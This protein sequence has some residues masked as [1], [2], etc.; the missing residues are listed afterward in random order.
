[1]GGTSQTLHL[2][3][4]KMNKRYNQWHKETTAQWLNEE[5]K[6]VFKWEPIKVA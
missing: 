5:L 3:S 6:K 2:K 4:N 1:M